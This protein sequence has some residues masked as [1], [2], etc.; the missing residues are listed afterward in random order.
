[1]R[2]AVSIMADSSNSRV[3]NGEV[4]ATS[5]LRNRADALLVTRVNLARDYS[6]PCCLARSM[7][8]RI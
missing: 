6:N 1:M 5:D 3:F 4:Y 8:R 2:S 7:V